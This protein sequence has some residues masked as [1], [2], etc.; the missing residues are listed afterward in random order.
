M[1][2]QKH[3]PPEMVTALNKEYEN[4][5]EWWRVLAG[6]PDTLI[7][8][9]NDYLNVYRN[10]C[11][12][13]KVEQD[14]DGQRASVHYKFLLKKKIDE[15]YIPCVNGSP[16]SPHAEIF[17]RSLRDIKD[18]KW[19]TDVLAGV[20][21]TGVHHIILANENVVD[22]EIALAGAQSA[23]ENSDLGLPTEVLGLKRKG[24]RI[25]FCA[26]QEERDGLFLRF[27]EAKHYSY[28][29][30][31]GGRPDSE[32]RVIHQLWEYHQKLKKQQTEILNAYRTSIKLANGLH[33][34]RVLGARLPLSCLDRLQLDPI[35]RLVVFG[36]DADHEQ[37]GSMFRKH[38]DRLKEELKKKFSMKDGGE[39]LLT[40]G[41]PK[42]FTNG[43]SVR[44]GRSLLPRG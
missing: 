7:A 28:R 25:D 41:S 8:I 1:T 26:A 6:D 43:V 44:K 4:K 12:I 11:S 42:R 22:T 31:F 36:Y 32:P 19:W 35:P 2:F 30:A 3:L 16:V 27:F 13:A 23:D 21:K 34:T 33:G 40:T 5:N 37:K 10:G 15:P 18:I 20:E 24:S 14:A 39:L 9:R 38:M 17:I 29:S